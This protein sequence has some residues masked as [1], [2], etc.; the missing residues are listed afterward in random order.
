M[1]GTAIHD[2]S[3]QDFDEEDGGGFIENLSGGQI[4]AEATLQNNN[5]NRNENFDISHTREK[6]AKRMKSQTSS[7]FYNWDSAHMFGQ[8]FVQELYEIVK[9]LVNLSGKTAI[10][11]L[12]YLYD[13]ILIDLC[14][15]EF[16]KYAAQRNIQ[17]S[18]IAPEIRV[19]LGV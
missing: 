7:I 14:E 19:V 16:I 10:Q 5:K 9:R 18:V 4:L 6:P 8:A 1:T 11:K 12:K 17:F 3:D 13:K 2:D 15:S